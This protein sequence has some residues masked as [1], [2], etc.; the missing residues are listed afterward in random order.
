VIY[1]AISYAARNM[2]KSVPKLTKLCVFKS[3]VE[4]IPYI[5]SQAIERPD[6]GRSIAWEGI[7]TIPYDHDAKIGT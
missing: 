2:S 4:N 1:Y 6:P 5:P 3:I 7:L